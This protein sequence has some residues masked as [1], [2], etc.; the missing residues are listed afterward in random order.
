MNFLDSTGEKIRSSVTHS[1]AGEPELAKTKRFTHVLKEKLREH[2]VYVGEQ[3]EVHY[4]CEYTAKVD[5][6]VRGK[7]AVVY[8]VAYRVYVTTH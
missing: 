1:Y 3:N 4:Y 5:M 6:F 2:N 8:H 7:N